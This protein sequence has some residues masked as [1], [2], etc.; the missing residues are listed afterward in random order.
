MRIGELAEL[1]RVSA[2][3]LRFYE[4]AGVLDEPTRNAAGYRDYEPAALS[5]L[6]FVKA[7]QAAG[8]TL[9][10]IRQVITVREHDG[11]PCE[12]VIALLDARVT[13]LDRRIK[14]LTALRG[15][16]HRLRRRARGLDPAQCD[17]AA[18]CHVIPATS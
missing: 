5:R 6:Q 1:S 9:A 2:R 8:L 16:V 17:D 4:L 7:A 18:V 13:D 12:H 10:Q 11:P 3:T 14:E 15:E